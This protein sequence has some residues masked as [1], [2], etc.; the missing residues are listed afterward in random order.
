MLSDMLAAGDTLLFLR[1]LTE[2][3][4]KRQVGLG[5]QL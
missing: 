3:S 5:P 4:L 1:F 2:L